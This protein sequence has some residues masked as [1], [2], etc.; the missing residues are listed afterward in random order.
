MRSQR[1]GLEGLANP[2]PR[3]HNVTTDSRGFQPSPVPPVATLRGVRG[4]L[5]VAL[6]AKGPATGE[7]SGLRA[8]ALQEG[9]ATISLRGETRSIRA[10]DR[11]GS[12]MVK[13]VG[14]DRI[15]LERSAR[16]AQRSGAPSQEAATIVVT[17]GSDG[18]ARVRTYVLV[19]S[20]VPPPEVR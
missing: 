4:A 14:A 7:L 15:V 10:G 16:D 1:D 11:L 6:F 19:G 2:G 12:S 5:P 9:N 13:A 3:V 20:T 8:V 18:Q 17:F